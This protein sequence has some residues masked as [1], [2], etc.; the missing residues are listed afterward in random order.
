MLN[1]KKLIAW[2]RERA[3]HAPPSDPPML[4]TYAIYTG[5]ADRIAR[6]DFDYEVNESGVDMSDG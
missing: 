6:G 1:E 4:V 5:L 2:L 3:K